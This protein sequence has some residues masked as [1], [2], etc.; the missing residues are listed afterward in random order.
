[1]R[2]HR[3]AVVTAFATYCLLVIG[4]LVHATGSSLACPDWPLCGGRVFPEMVGGILFEHGHRLAAL[5]VAVLTVALAAIIWR[6]HRDAHLRALAALA[7]VLLLFQAAL[8]AITVLLRLPLIVSA[9]HLTTSMAFFCL[10]IYLAWRLR[11]EPVPALRG[12]PRHLAGFAV[13]AVFAQIVLGA[14]VR[15]TGSGMA[16]GID[17]LFCHGSLWPGDGPGRLLSSHRIAG[18]LVFALVL[19]T[20]VPAWQVTRA[21]GR[22][23]GCLLAAAAPL[24]V[25]AQ[26]SLGLLTVTTYISVPVVTAHLAVGAL[27]LADVW[28][29]LLSFGPGGASAEVAGGDRRPGFA[30]VVG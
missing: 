3:V 16:C 9:G 4:A 27:L 26:I 1:M 19:A 10:M 15:H 17:V 12:A 21:A 13:A 7:V 24:L 14:L 5:A 18:A 6:R 11:P 2:E 22:R 29:L 20:A 23:A 28:A 30:P 25:I 8:G